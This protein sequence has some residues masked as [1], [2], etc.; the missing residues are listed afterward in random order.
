MN[1]MG[2]TSPESSDDM[3]VVVV[4]G[5]AGPTAIPADEGDVSRDEDMADNDDDDDESDYSYAYEDEDEDEGYF[6][7]YLIPTYPFE[8][9]TMT[10][11]PPAVF[12]E[13]F[14]A[15]RLVPPPKR[16]LQ[17][18]AEQSRGPL[19]PPPPLRSVPSPKRA[20]QTAAE[21]SRGPLSPQPRSVPSPKR[22]L[23]T[24]AE[25]SRDPPSSSRRRC[26]TS[27]PPGT[28]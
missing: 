19:S 13:D 28:P 22:A 7:G 14:A 15:A 8:T 4:E 23:Q 27:S 26:S 16:A 10:G 6:S 21:Q 9:T 17:T 20:L 3:S 24:A 1:H 18:A 25:Q 12:A 11:F 2:G 5:G